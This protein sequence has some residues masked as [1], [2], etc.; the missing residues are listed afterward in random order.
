MFVSASSLCL[1]SS[2]I[3][4]QPPHWYYTLCR[5][6]QPGFH[7]AHM[8]TV[9]SVSGLAHEAASIFACTMLGKSLR[10]PAYR[11]NIIQKIPTILYISQPSQTC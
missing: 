6:E 11:K 5:S 3:G 7:I 2:R 9:K 4:S 1:S 8:I 10:C